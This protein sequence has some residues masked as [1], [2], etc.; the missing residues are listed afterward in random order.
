LADILINNIPV[1]LHVVIMQI[2]D[3]QYSSFLC[4]EN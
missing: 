2:P 1:K 3:N 4:I